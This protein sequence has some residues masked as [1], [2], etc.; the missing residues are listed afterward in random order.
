MLCGAVVES[1][2][3]EEKL[4]ANIRM[5]GQWRQ[6]VSDAILI[7]V[8]RRPRMQGLLA[9][10]AG[11]ELEN[12]LI[13]VSDEFKTSAEGVFA[14]GDLVS[15]IQLA[16]VAAAQGTYVVEKIAGM[17]HGTQPVSYTHLDVYK[18]QAPAFPAE[19]ARE[20]ASPAPWPTIRRSF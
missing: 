8:G 7:S 16:H 11:V 10:D 1:I 15:R 4:A 20:S 12:G 19:C 9:E 3:R 17:A 6:V 14:V 5:A 2:S 18:R 13:R